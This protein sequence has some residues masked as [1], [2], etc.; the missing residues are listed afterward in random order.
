MIIDCVDDDDD[1]D[2]D[3]GDVDGRFVIRC[4]FDNNGI[5]FEFSKV[6]VASLLCVG[7]GTLLLQQ[8]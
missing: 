7:I 5:E 2:D 3:D 6:N 4:V 8:G 1:D